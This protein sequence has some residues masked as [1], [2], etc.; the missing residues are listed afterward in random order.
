M[1]L[2]ASRVLT[3]PSNGGRMTSE[4]RNVLYRVGMR[5][6]EQWGIA[7][8]RMEA[9]GAPAGICREPF[10]AIVW[11]DAIY[12]CDAL[13]RGLPIMPKH[14]HRESR[15]TGRAG[16]SHDAGDDRHE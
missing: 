16:A 8:H 4:G 7:L 5:C 12:I 14:E 6:A 1:F 15:R 13:R 11:H 9:D 10:E 2:R 3:D